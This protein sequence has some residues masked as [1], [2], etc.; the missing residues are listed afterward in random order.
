MLLYGSQL[1]LSLSPIGFSHR[2]RCNFL[3][4]A[5]LGYKENAER[6][7]EVGREEAYR[8]RAVTMHARFLAGFMPFLPLSVSS[9]E[10]SRP[11]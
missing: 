1:P 2:G 7:E 5:K 10:V 6:I 9:P 3:L 4:P 8:A 11:D